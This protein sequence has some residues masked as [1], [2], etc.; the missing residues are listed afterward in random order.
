MQTKIQ[1]E[2]KYKGE[3]LTAQ[4]MS[5][6]D[7]LASTMPDPLTEGRSYFIWSITKKIKVH[8]GTFNERS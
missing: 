1:V 7:N 6:S 4:I 8:L 3:V 2:A 5:Y